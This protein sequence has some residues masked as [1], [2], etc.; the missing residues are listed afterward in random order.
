LAS[1]YAEN[2]LE[3][4]FDGREALPIGVPNYVTDADNEDREHQL[5]RSLGDLFER[6]PEAVGGHVS[7]DPWIFYERCLEMLMIRVARSRRGLRGGRYGLVFGYTSGLDLVG[8]VAY[9]DP[10]LQTRAYAE[11]DEFVGELRGDLGPDDELLLVSDHGLQDG[12]HT[13]EAMVAGTNPDTVAAIESVTG[14][15]AAIEAALEAGDHGPSSPKSI[16]TG[17]GPGANANAGDS[18]AVREQL[19]DLGYM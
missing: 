18:E 4:V 8:H 12:V 15:R 5:R 11:A 17:T 7:A 9:Q 3:T 16:D 19:E 14:V 10:E 6:D 13:H 2:G 1:Y